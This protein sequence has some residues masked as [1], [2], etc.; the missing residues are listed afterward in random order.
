[1]KHQWTTK[2]FGSKTSVCDNVSLY[3]VC[4][5]VCSLESKV[6]GYYPNNY[7]DMFRVKMS[8]YDSPGTTLGVPKV[9]PN[10]GQATCPSQQDFFPWWKTSA[11]WKGRAIL[12]PKLIS[13]ILWEVRTT[14]RRVLLPQQKLQ[15]KLGEIWLI[16][17][18][19]INVGVFWAFGGYVIYWFCLVVEPD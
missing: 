1:M 2:T 10:F 12:C 16:K 13:K 17:S 8:R 4:V 19:P 9:H 7:M 5:Y 15:K 6:N 18:G 11:S 3:V 14:L